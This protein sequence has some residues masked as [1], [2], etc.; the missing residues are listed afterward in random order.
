ML[1]G[2]KATVV[3]KGEEKTRAALLNLAKDY[4]DDCRRLLEIRTRLSRPSATWSDAELKSRIS[5]LVNDRRYDRIVP[6]PAPSE[7]FSVS[8]R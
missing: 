5:I 3:W 6:I 8:A 7:M 2:G 4:V 1:R